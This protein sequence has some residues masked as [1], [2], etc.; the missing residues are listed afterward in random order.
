MKTKHKRL[1]IIGT[2]LTWGIVSWGFVILDY[3]FWHIRVS[4]MDRHQYIAPEYLDFLFSLFTISSAPALFTYFLASQLET[5]SEYLKAILWLVCFISQI[6]C[7][8][9]LG[10][11]L[12]RLY[13]WLFKTIPPEE[14][15]PQKDE[16]T[17][18]GG[19]D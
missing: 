9:Y 11:L 7:Y 13:M 14:A 19:R 2:F 4:P 10:S 5:T 17:A 15:E 8:W 3:N 12:Y 6:A 1:I 16:A 18:K